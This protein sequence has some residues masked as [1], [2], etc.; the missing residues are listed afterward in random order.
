[1]N[2]ILLGPPGSGKGTQA[3]F[4]KTH[5]GLMHL[6]TGER[7]RREIAEGT[8]LGHQAK[9]IID[10]GQYVSD[11]LIM[12][13]VADT[14]DRPEYRVGV[15]FDGYPRTVNQAQQLDEML[16]TKGRTIDHVIEPTVNSTIESNLDTVKPQNRKKLASR[17]Y[18]NV[19]N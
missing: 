8:A 3:D 19:G 9:E 7:L 13:L 15:I 14:L 12:K 1:M 16:R 5:Y 17:K 11:D 10:S 6:Q 18:H 2:I 4:L